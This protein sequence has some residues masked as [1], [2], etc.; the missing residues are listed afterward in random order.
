MKRRGGLAALALIPLVSGFAIPTWAG[1][2]TSGGQP[3][4][5]APPPR[6]EDFF[7]RYCAD[8]FQ[9]VYGPTDRY[10]QPKHSHPYLEV[11][12]EITRRA[13]FSE[14][15]VK[16]DDDG[17]HELQ[18][19]STYGSARARA[20]LALHMEQEWKALGAS[21]AFAFE[22][23]L[24]SGGV[25]SVRPYDPIHFLAA[26]GWHEPI[27]EFE[28]RTVLIHLKPGPRLEF[29]AMPDKTMADFYRRKAQAGY[30]VKQ[31]EADFA[32]G[33]ASRCYLSILQSR[34][35]LSPEEKRLVAAMREVVNKKARNAG[36]PEWDPDAD[37]AA[38]LEAQKAGGEHPQSQDSPGAGEGK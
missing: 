37:V 29:D 13:G 35:K 30:T 36:R 12:E 38:L 27:S 1:G 34:G 33:I 5:G 10:I 26:E 3:V 9:S 14:K 20:A 23:R 15:W 31:I 17:A 11:S 19:V 21:G 2:L 18:H 16:L 22:R 6:E 4:K 28:I 32:R 7:Y 25:T 8:A 24:K